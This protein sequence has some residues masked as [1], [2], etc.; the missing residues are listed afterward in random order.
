M[1]CRRVGEG[2][3]SFPESCSE[4]LR[5]RFRLV[6]VLV[7]PEH[8]TGS[9]PRDEPQI[10]PRG[11][12]SSYTST[13]W[14]SGRL[15][16]PEVEARRRTCQGRRHRC[17]PSAAS[18]KQWIRPTFVSPRNLCRRTTKLTRRGRCKDAV[19]REKRMRPRSWCNTW[20]GGSFRMLQDRM[21]QD[22]SSEPQVLAFKWLNLLS[23]GNQRLSASIGL[24]EYMPTSL[25]AR[26]DGRSA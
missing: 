18:C 14:E 21:L 11:S 10:P 3:D 6:H 5:W 22:F 26:S 24:S 2:P 13:D 15:S 7:P 16:G 20:F 23:V 19:S 8:R 4:P 17:G 9:W 25:L 12:H 1:V